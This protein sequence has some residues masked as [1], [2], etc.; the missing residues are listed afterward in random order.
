MNPE[1]LA[2]VS[3][4]EVLRDAPPLP[5]LTHPLYDLFM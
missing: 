2:S 4:G 3:V 5:E 1:I